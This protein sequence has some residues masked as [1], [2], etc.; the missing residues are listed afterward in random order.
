[1][2]TVALDDLSSVN[3]PPVRRPDRPG[4]NKYYYNRSFN[5]DDTRKDC[6][7]TNCFG[8]S[9]FVW[10]LGRLCYGHIFF[11]M[12]VTGLCLLEPILVAHDPVGTNL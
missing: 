8:I 6:F 12:C 11:W 5:F 7:S 10:S 2:E 9:R 3:E 4:F 1:M